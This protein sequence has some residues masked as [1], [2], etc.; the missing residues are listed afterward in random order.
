MRGLYIGK[1]LPELFVHYEPS[2]EGVRSVR[3]T[4]GKYFPVQ[5]ESDRAILVKIEAEPRDIV[6]VQV[7]MP[8]S[9][10]EDE[11]VDEVYEQINEFIEAEKGND[12]LILMGDWNAVIGEGEHGRDVSK[13]GHGRRNERG[14]KLVEFCREKKLM[15]TNTW[16]EQENRRRYTWKQPGDTNRYQL[17]YILVRQ[18]YRN[19]VKKSCSFPRS[20]CRIRSQLSYDEDYGKT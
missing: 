20:R 10:S 1:Y 7:Y 2:D 15:V 6:A 12:Y 19:S 4:E 13:Y 14:E 11:K 16:F 3:K 9:S 5:T 17:D 18:R 8:T